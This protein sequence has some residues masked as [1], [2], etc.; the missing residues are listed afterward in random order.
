MRL[1]FCF[2][3]LSL[4]FIQG[5]KS[6]EVIGTAGDFFQSDNFSLAWTLG[7]P[8]S[9]TGE[10]NDNILTQGFHQGHF[11]LV[12]IGEKEEPDTEITVYP[13]PFADVLNIRFKQGQPSEKALYQIFDLTGKAVVSGRLNNPENQINLGRLANSQYLLVII[14]SSTNF[15]ETYSVLKTN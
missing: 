7:E 11:I 15:K 1:F 14:D 4:T 2:A 6:Q 3:A 9:E 12:Y 8:V 10:S 13:N 5:V